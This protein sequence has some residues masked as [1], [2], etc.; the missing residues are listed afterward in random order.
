MSGRYAVVEVFGRDFGVFLDTCAWFVHFVPEAKN[1]I[2]FV[3]IDSVGRVHIVCVGLVS[4]ILLQ[5]K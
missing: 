1:R 3:R 2:F 4:W 5:D